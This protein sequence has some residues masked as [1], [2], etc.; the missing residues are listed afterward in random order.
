[1]YKYSQLSLEQRYQIEALY[2]AGKSQSEI[3]RSLGFHRSTISREFKRNIAIRGSN[4]KEYLA[5]RA[6]E[7]TVERHKIKAKHI[8]FTSE[9]KN[10]ARHWIVEEKLSPELVSARFYQ[11]KIS[12]S[13]E[14]IYR[15]IWE[16]K[17]SN[18]REHR[19]DKYLYAHLKHGKRRRKRGAYRQNRGL[20]PGRNSIENR[21]KIVEKRT[22]IGDLEIDLMMG[23]RHK[24]SLLVILDRTSLY[25]FIMKVN[26]R[27]MSEISSKLKE[28][29]MPHRSWIKT[30]TFDNDPAFFGHMSVADVLMAKTY[31]T[32][33]YTSQDKGSVENRIGILRRFFPKK[34]PLEDVPD[35][36][37]AKVQEILN[38][39]PVRKFNYKTPNQI[40]SQKLGVALIS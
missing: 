31:F 8:R 16:C 14:T 35:E 12:I 1:M 19:I 27:S 34:T 32:R 13:A 18:R 22:R 2:K 30:L 23:K 33:P 9:L 21:P 38:N 10:Q 29:L 7:K 17:R 11:I 40:F 39:R 15:W 20:I 25:T 4:A 28:K 6:Q 5:N 36:R 24:A 3:S 37:I 26:S